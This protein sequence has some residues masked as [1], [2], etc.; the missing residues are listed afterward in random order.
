MPANTR[1]FGDSERPVVS[2]PWAEGW[3][4]RVLERLRQLGYPS[5]HSFLQANRGLRYDDLVRSLGIETAPVQVAHLSLLEAQR[6][7]WLEWG[8]KDSLCRHLADSLPRGLT[9]T[10]RGRFGVASATSRWTVRVKTAT[11]DD[12][13]W[14]SVCERVSAR[15]LRL[16]A[17]P[18][19][20]PKDA[21]DE[22]LRSLF[23][24]ASTPERHD[25]D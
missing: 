16:E 25:D 22:A 14:R 10:A 4:G 3:E 5:F 21:D 8:I 12:P 19:W 11:E 15:L 6:E 7:G 23:E 13:Y 17:R 18:G 9:Q 20:I 24:D 2:T 1:S